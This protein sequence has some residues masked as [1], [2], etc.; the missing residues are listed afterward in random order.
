MAVL[1]GN[2]AGGN[3]RSVGGDRNPETSLCTVSV[4]E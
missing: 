3:S 4:L 2:K 1:E